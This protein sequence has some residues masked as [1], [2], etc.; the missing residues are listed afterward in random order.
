MIGHFRAFVFCVIFLTLQLATSIAQSKPGEAPAAPVPQQILSAKKVFI[1]NAGGD[2]MA[3]GEPIFSGGTDRAYNQ[4]YA[5]VKNWGRF[6]VVGSPAQADL[7]LEI[8]QETQMVVLGGKAGG[9]AIPLFKLKI[10]DPKTNMLLWAFRI[11]GEFGLGQGNSDRN[12]DQAV[13]RL[14]FRF[15]TLLAQATPDKP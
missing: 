1:A 12:F 13:Y 11:H 5:A 3:P 9:S 15:Q 6:E 2:E 4:F 10:I 7:V 8:R 14:V